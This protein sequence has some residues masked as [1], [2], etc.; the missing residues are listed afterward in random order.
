MLILVNVPLYDENYFENYFHYHGAEIKKLRVYARNIYLQSSR[1][2]ERLLNAKW[3]TVKDTFHCH[4][5]RRATCR[6]KPDTFNFVDHSVWR[7]QHGAAEWRNWR[8]ISARQQLVTWP[9]PEQP[10]ALLIAVAHSIC[11]RTMDWSA[12]GMWSAKLRITLCSH[13]VLDNYPVS[14]KRDPDIFDCNFKKN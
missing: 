7:Q 5:D 10:E 9:R 12:R 8:P 6:Q 14:Q 2:C 11:M 3:A 13:C 1:N 4:T